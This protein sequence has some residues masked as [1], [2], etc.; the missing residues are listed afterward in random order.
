MRQTPAPRTIE[1]IIDYAWPATTREAIAPGW[2]AR[3]AG[4]A[5][6]RANSLLVLGTPPDTD[7]AIA[8]AERWYAA[9]G[10]PAVFSIGPSAPAALD[11]ELAGR[12]YVVADRTMIM[13]APVHSR[14]S[15][16]VS[17]AAEPSAAWF[18]TWWDVD[19]DRHPAA[20]G[21]E[22]ARRI[23]TGVP[24]AYASC[25]PDAVG[26]GVVQGEWLSVWCMAVRAAARRQGL[27]GR[28]LGGLMEWGAAA[29]ARTAVLAVVETNVAARAL[30]A[31]AGFVDCGRYHYRVGGA[32][33]PTR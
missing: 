1:E 15:S 25:G 23:A 31:A 4:G 11:A 33:S 20:D 7:R 19:G 14:P 8:A 3:A 29:G 17:V 6:K 13:A 5:T 16:G 10:L 27:G 22:W 24:A 2:T 32:T 28:I 26:R 12:G 30:Y 21:R 9:H 18:D